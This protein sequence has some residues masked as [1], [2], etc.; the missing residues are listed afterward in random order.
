MPY[1][2]K[3]PPNAAKDRV[4]GEVE[5]A[6]GAPTTKKAETAET[7]GN[8]GGSQPTA[9]SGTSATG[10]LGQALPPPPRSLKP[11]QVARGV[12]A[13][14]PVKDEEEPVQRAPL[15]TSEWPVV[16]YTPVRPDLPQTPPIRPRIGLCPSC[17]QR[18]LTSRDHD[19]AWKVIQHELPGKV[20]CPGSGLS[21]P[22]E[23]LKREPVVKTPV[24][25]EPGQP[26]R[27]PVPPLPVPEP[28]EKP[29]VQRQPVLPDASDPAIPKRT[30]VPSYGQLIRREPVIAEPRIKRTPVR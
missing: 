6:G 5:P 4:S 28:V 7:A 14:Q 24:P 9:S 26:L 20:R 3:F 22:G 16:R 2:V 27:Q 23:P 17:R 21:V 19:G 15:L 12:T 8:G 13:K 18:M 29:K 1:Q 11:H 10:R 25:P 30:P